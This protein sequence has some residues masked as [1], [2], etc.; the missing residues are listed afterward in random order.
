MSYRLR[1][2]RRWGVLIAAYLPSLLVGCVN[3]APIARQQADIIAGDFLREFQRDQPGT[4]RMLGHMEIEEQDDGWAYRW[5]CQT[6]V[7]SGLGVFVER[8]GRADY[9]DAPDCEG[10][11]PS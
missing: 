9:S 3:D 4:A 7:D 5:K 6:G 11:F 10:L 1:R 8:S 2:K